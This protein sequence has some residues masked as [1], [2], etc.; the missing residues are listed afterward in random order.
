M[1]WRT[2]TWSASS[3]LEANGSPVDEAIVF[4]MADININNTTPAV[5]GWQSND[6]AF[7][8]IEPDPKF[9]DITLTT[10]FDTTCSLFELSVPIK[11]KEIRLKGDKGGENSISTLLLRICPST[12]DTF[13]FASAT[14]SPE[15][16]RPKFTSYVTRLDFQLNKTLD[17]LVPTNTQDPPIPARAYSGIILDAIRQ[18]SNVTSLSI[19]V[20]DTV[21]SDRDLQCLSDAFSQGLF[22]S[23]RSSQHALASLYGGNGAKIIR[24][25][26]QTG[27][28]PPPYREI[29][30]PPPSAP[31]DNKKRPR[32]DS[33]NERDNDIAQIWAVL[34]K[35]KERDTRNEALENENRCLRK[36]IEELRER[37]AVLEKQKDDNE[38]VEAQS[39]DNTMAL[40]DIDVELA[41]MREDIR[42]LKAKADSV[43]R[44]ELAEMVKHDVLEYMRVRLFDD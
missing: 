4:D 14:T 27:Q 28:N 36:E 13:S 40:V 23:V 39:N 22:K 10:R 30:P 11:M 7:S 32:Q 24:L 17:V 33:Q 8:L 35:I 6:A 44:G 37:V 2:D 5:I 31:I 41:D 42:E 43:E 15:S 16:T 3:A 34:A 29:T 1:F 20:Q 21:L 19:Y 38:H 12:V 25:S 18:L 9:S 26:A